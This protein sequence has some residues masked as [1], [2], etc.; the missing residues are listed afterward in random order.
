MTAAALLR[1]LADAGVHVE[2]ADGSLVVVPASKL[3]DGH[4]AS[5]RALKPELLALLSG[6]PRT[7]TTCTHRLRA[8]TCAVP[9]QS[10]LI[11]AGSGFGIFWPP[12][13][14]AATCPAWCAKPTSATATRPYKLTAAQGDAAHAEPW[15]D[16]AITR[17]KARAAD[18]QRRGFGE[19]DADD[20]AELLHLRDASGDHRHLCVECKHLAGTLTTGLRCRAGHPVGQDLATLL[21]RCVSFRTAHAAHQITPGST[22]ATAQVLAYPSGTLN[23]PGAKETTS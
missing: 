5:L 18:I 12:A 14:H 16:G 6:A 10:G 20:L 8:G 21:Q 11:P 9:E 1:D 4:R 23:A 13:A 7:C 17:F 15:D 19:Q 22:N 3:S 2:A